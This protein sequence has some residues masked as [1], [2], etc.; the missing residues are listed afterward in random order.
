M[1]GIM[2]QEDTIPM[3][4]RR[5]KRK[6]R[7]P[8]PPERLARIRKLQQEIRQQKYRAQEKLEAIFE[9]LVRDVNRRTRR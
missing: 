3:G 9:D 2:Q 1:D 8:I 4:T 7:P 6:K 5:E